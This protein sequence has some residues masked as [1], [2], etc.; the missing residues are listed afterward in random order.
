[1]Q[2]HQRI[3]A[4]RNLQGDTYCKGKGQDT[5][6]HG[7]HE[8]AE[9]CRIATYLADKYGYEIDLL[10]KRDDKKMAD[11]FNRTLNKEQEYK[12]N[13][14]A[15]KSAIDNLLRD[16]GKQAGSIVIRIDSDIPFGT[17]RDAI[18]DR[19][20]RS[21]NITDIIIIRDGKDVTFTREQMVSESFKIQQEDFE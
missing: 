21:K 3:Q 14:T 4:R 9:N 1:M 15:T 10:P 17:I 6:Q 12:V 20:R 7:K 5:P 13:G 8:A 19:V 18:S 11:T 16:G 2:A